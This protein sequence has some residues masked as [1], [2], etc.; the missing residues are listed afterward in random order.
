L[1]F[2]FKLGD[3]P[4]F[5]FLYY[6][7]G[8]NSPLQRGVYSPR[9]SKYWQGEILNKWIRQQWT[10]W[11]WDYAVWN[12]QWDW[13]SWSWDYAGWSWDYAGW[14]WDYDE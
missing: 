8:P 5:Y 11:D 1:V 2:Y 6:G 3:A 13:T 14:S 7:G 9:G 10:S 4:G 12:W